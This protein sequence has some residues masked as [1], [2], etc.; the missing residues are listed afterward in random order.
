MALALLVPFSGVAL[1]S[2]HAQWFTPSFPMSYENPPTCDAL[3]TSELSYMKWTDADWKCQDPDY[4]WSKW[5][6]DVCDY[7][8]EQYD[9]VDH[10][11][12][13]LC[14]CGC[15]CVPK[16]DQS[17]WKHLYIGADDDCVVIFNSD[18]AEYNGEW[19]YGGLYGGRRSWLRSPFM[20]AYFDEDNAYFLTP[21]YYIHNGG[22]PITF[23][24]DPNDFGDEPSP[25]HCGTWK[26]AT[27]YGR[28]G[29]IYDDVDEGMTATY[30]A[31]APDLADDD[32]TPAETHTFGDFTFVHS[33]WSALLFVAVPVMLTL[34]VVLLFVICCRKVQKTTN[35]EKVEMVSSAEDDEEP[36]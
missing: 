20:L 36:M 6:T 16:T 19:I 25:T 21:G 17:R 12:W 13:S 2:V 27:N 35:Y 26:H 23:F 5:I 9:P 1:V 22:Y 15:G 18:L 34:N 29:A 32:M 31:L 28:D 33:K 24:D 11:P 3:S 10:R 4:D 8:D 30:C 7:A 14:G